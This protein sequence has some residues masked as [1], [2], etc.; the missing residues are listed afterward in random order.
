MATVLTWITLAV[1]AVVV[2]VLATYLILIGVAL[3]RA[4][5]NLKLLAGGLAAIQG[6]SQPLPAHLTTIN[7]ALVTL[8]HGLQSV[9]GHLAGIARLF[10]R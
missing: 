3:M 7:G 4:N 6:H 9:D 10:K 5:R 2:L 8:L 1:L